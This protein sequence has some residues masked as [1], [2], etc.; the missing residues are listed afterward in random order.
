MLFQ[1]LQQIQRLINDSKMEIANT[2]NLEVFI[3]M[4]RRQVAGET[5]CLRALLTSTL[6]VGQR[7]YAYTD[8]D[9]TGFAGYSQVLQIRSVMYAVGSGYQWINPRNFEWF[10]LYYLNNPTAGNP[11]PDVS[12]EPREWS[13]Y[14][15]GANVGQFYIE[16]IPQYAYPLLLDCVCIPADLTAGDSV[17]AI[18]FPWT[19]TVPYF[20]AYLALLNA[21][22]MDAAKG[23]M[24]LY[25]VF[26][27]RSRQMAN[28][29]VDNPMYP[30]A[31]DPAQLQKLGL[32]PPA[33]QG[34]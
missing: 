33:P 23:M 11:D 14:R 32:R 24:D 31:V 2:G 19:D 15:Q 26:V 13:Q 7:S 29:A 4:A 30:Q 8:I 12:Q 25:K 20:A 10:M 22:K 28:P 27:D 17:E 34:G 21:Q 9:L 1:Y 5:E 3:N 6:V 18:P 16:P